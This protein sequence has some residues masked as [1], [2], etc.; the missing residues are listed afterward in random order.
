MKSATSFGISTTREDV[1]RERLIRDRGYSRRRLR[2]IFA[3]SLARRSIAA[4]VRL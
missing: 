1:R 3:A 2:Q 4:P